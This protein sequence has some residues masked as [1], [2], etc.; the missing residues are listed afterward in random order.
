MASQIALSSHV[1]GDPICR[2]LLADDSRDAQ[3]LIRLYL[4]GLPY[5]L[6][7]AGDGKEA[8]ALYQAGQFDLVLLDQNMPVMDGFTATREIRAWEC[9]H[10]QAPVPIVAFTADSGVEAMEEGRTAGCTGFL[11]KPITQAQLFETLHRYGSPSST[12]RAAPQTCAPA[13]IASLIDE[14]I[15][16]RRPLFLDN[17]RQELKRLQD[18][19][20]QGDDEFIRITGHRIKGLAGSYGFP[21]IGLAGAQLEQAARDQDLAAM[22]RAIDQLSALLAHASQAV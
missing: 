3:A 6:D 9:S 13:G 17:R 5:Q 10:Q 18:A 8:V 12:T 11:T 1:A 16:R 22:R 15:A 20:E 7:V 4:H 19:I 21:D 2:I 14:E